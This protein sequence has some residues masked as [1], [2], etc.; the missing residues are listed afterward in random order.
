MAQK[1]YQPDKR[2]IEPGCPI[3]TLA[4]R[5]WSVPML[6]LRQ[7]RVVLPELIRVIPD[8]AEFQSNQAAWSEDNLES[9][10]AIVHGAL[11]RA[12]PDMTRD[13]FLDLPISAWELIS[14]L[15]PIIRQTRYF[16]TAEKASSDG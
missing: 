6:A 8:L 9:I 2:L 5:E 16:N 1:T 10:I 11:T 7:S 15:P 4:G 3:V 14:A 12:Y 13:E